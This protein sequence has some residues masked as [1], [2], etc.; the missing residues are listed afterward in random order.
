MGQARAQRQQYHQGSR[1]D[2]SVAKRERGQ[3]QSGRAGAR[4]KRKEKRWKLGFDMGSA[5]TGME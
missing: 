4:H 3:G 5:T 1:R 2:K